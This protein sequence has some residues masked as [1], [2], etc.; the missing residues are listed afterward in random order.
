[1]M[2]LLSRHRS[3]RVQEKLSDL[4]AQMREMQG[5]IAELQGRRADDEVEALAAER[6]RSGAIESA[7]DGTRA[8]AELGIDIR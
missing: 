1:M 5:A 8:L 2:A 7:E 3:R 4:E 6:I